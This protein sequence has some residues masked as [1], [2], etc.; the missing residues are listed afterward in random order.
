MKTLKISSGHIRFGD[1]VH[2][3]NQ[4]AIILSAKT[5]DWKCEIKTE[6]KYNNI[7]IVC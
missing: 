6:E 2:Q 1:P 5:G 7:S 4:F 3:D